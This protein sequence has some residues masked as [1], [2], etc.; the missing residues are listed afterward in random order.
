MLFLCS[1]VL[2]HLAKEVE[3]PYKKDYRNE[4]RVEGAS[5]SQSSEWSAEESG[6]LNQSFRSK[7]QPDLTQIHKTRTENPSRHTLGNT[8]LVPRDFNSVFS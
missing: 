8:R 5:A 1:Q 4:N 7:S 2:K 6:V 3:V